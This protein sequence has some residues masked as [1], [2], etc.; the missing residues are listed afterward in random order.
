MRY[1]RRCGLADPVRAASDTAPTDVAVGPTVYRITER[2][3]IGSI[4]SVYRCQFFEGPVEHEAVVKIARDARVNALLQ[5]EAA[6]L[7]RLRAADPANRYTPFLPYPQ[8]VFSIAD[9]P[10]A[11]PR[12]A[13]VVRTH[14]A[15]RRPADELYTLADIRHHFAA[16]L[17][18]RHVAW[19]WR[20]LLTTLGFVH[21]AGVVHGQVLPPH[22]LVEPAE[23]KVVLV[24]WTC[25]V[26]LSRHTGRALP[27]VAGPYLSWFRKE[28]PS[29]NPASPAIDIALGARS[30]IDLLGGDPL[31][32]RLPPTLDPALQRY[33]SRCISFAPNARPDAGRL[34]SDFDQLIEALWGPRSFLP[35]ELPPRNR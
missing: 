1:C 3:A 11:P 30:M 34:L 24:D 31:T 26:D 6:T 19:I 7:A 22:V 35:L 27:V 8:A 10:P 16:G 18:A 17:D 25:A 13:L 15:I 14:P 23:H 9:P 4:S 2:I 21:G 32:G 12:S 5:S 33:F 29:R 20:R 28:T